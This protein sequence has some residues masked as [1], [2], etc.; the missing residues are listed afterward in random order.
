MNDLRPVRPAHCCRLGLTYHTAN[1]NE[2]DDNLGRLPEL[3]YV[4]PLPP[5]HFQGLQKLERDVHV[6]Y[7]RDPHRAKEAH[8]DGLTYVLDLVDELLHA[9]DDRGA[10]EEQNEYAQG[11]ESV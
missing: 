11:D 7:S 8:E 5:I 3:F 6:E 9:E 1:C 2:P 10:S 4:L